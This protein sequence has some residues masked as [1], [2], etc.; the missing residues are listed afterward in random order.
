[1]DHATLDVRFRTILLIWAS[2]LGGVTLFT[3]A[4]LALTT[5]AIG[6]WT[7]TLDPELA[8]PL[9]ILPVS[10]MVGGIVF[11]RGEAKRSGDA[12]QRLTA[13]QNQVIVGAALQEGGGLLGLVLCLLAGQPTW[14]VG[15]WAV[16]A[17][18]MGLTR[19]T[20]DELD[21]LLR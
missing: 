7:P 21:L 20:R 10:S 5:G 9:M 1:M 15:V 18:A 3:G 14:A 12:A 2:L 17:V 13:Y 19:P 16:T 4:V 6:A 11:R 8:A